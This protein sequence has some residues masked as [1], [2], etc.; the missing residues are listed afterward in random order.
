LP[1]AI[2]HEWDLTV[3]TLARMTKRAP[4]GASLPAPQEGIEVIAHGIR[5]VP[6][7][8]DA[9]LDCHSNLTEPIGGLSA[10]MIYWERPQGGRVFHAGAVGAAWVIGSDPN[11]GKLLKN[12]LYR[13]GVQPHA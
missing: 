1:R 4:P 3:A 10:E 8:L 9:Y 12:V 11:F 2:G 7:R 6:G 5:R 13:F